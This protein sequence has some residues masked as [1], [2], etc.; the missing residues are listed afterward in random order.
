MRV[1]VDWD[2]LVLGGLIMV[3]VVVILLQLVLGGSIGLGLIGFS[4]GLLGWW[5]FQLSGWWCWV[6]GW[7]VC[8]GGGLFDWV[9]G[10]S[11]VMVLGASI[12]WWWVCGGGPILCWFVVV[13][14]GLVMVRWFD[15]AMAVCVC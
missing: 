1:F 10:D 12:G 7:W 8:G 5:W 14:L 2:G 9:G 6:G 11:I 3:V 4:G 13:R 15:C